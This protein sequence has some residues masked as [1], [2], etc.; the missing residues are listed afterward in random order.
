LVFRIL[1][2]NIIYYT[3]FQS[4]HVRTPRPVASKLAAD[5]PLLTDQ[6]SSMFIL[7]LVY[8]IKFFILIV[9]CLMTSV[10]CSVF[11]MPFFPQCLVG[12]VP[13]L[14]LSVVAKQSLVR[15][16]LR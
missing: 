7:C 6:V 1:Y 16:F 2:Y 15:L 8:M 9:L 4:W 11:L 5:T 12:L 14:G 3:N 13:Y 10:L